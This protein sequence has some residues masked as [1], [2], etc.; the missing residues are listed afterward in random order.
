MSMK[1]VLCGVAVSAISLVSVAAFADQPQLTQTQTIVVRYSSASLDRDRGVAHLYERIHRAANW[2]CGE[3][4]MTGSL[5][6][7]TDYAR[8]VAAAVEHAVGNID[9]GA[10]TA[11]YQQQLQN[12][13]EFVAGD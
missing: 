5:Y 13:R 7:A 11:Y 3:P 12:H 1:N 4:M 2:A 8:C 10:L 6:A 9:N